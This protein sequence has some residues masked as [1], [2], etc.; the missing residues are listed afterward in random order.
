[1]DSVNMTDEQF[2]LAMLQLR[3]ELEEKFGKENAFILL[4]GTFMVSAIKH[5]KTK[6]DL[7]ELTDWA[8]GQ[9]ADTAAKIP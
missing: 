5:G 3:K 6:A 8:Y 4:T 1:M 9:A 7:H 2:T